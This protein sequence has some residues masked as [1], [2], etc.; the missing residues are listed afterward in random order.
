MQSNERGS[1]KQNTKSVQTLQNIA[2]TIVWSLVKVQALNCLKRKL[3][4]PLM[5][6]AHMLENIFSKTFGAETIFEM[7]SSSA[8]NGST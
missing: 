3:Q 7:H 8:Q 4:K 5:M 2:P 6:Y 1:Q